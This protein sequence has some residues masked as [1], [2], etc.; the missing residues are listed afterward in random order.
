MLGTDLAN[1]RITGGSSGSSSVSIEY[2][3]FSFK[4]VLLVLSMLLLEM[5]VGGKSGPVPLDIGFA[6]DGRLIGIAAGFPGS[7]LGKSAK[8]KMVSN[9]FQGLDKLKPIQLATGLQS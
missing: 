6:S 9:T 5:L 2:L 3:C 7:A 1:F 4:L 8:I